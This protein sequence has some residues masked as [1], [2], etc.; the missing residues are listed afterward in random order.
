MC[1]TEVASG[2]VYLDWERK[3]NLKKM[4]EEF[5]MTVNVPLAKITKYE[6]D[7]SGC[8]YNC[9]NGLCLN[10]SA[11]YNEK[12]LQRIRDVYEENDM[13]TNEM[14][15]CTFAKKFEDGIC[16]HCGTVSCGRDCDGK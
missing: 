5:K 7:K 8:I 4:Q 15:E 12:L 14:F 3:A 13:I 6:C 9:G 16:I 10:T 11:S 2:G 1:K